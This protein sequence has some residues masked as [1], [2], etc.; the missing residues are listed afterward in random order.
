[1]TVQRHVSWP[2]RVVFVLVLVGTFLIGGKW[3]YEL[4]R[5]FAGFGEDLHAE[6]TR[7]RGE[8][9]SLRSERESL[10]KSEIAAQSRLS[11]ERSTQ[12]QLGK[13]IKSLEIENAKLKDDISFFENL[14]ASGPL[15]GLAIKRM[16]VERDV[17]PGQFHYRILVTQGGKIDHDFNGDL[18]LLVSLQH[19]GKTV[20]MNLPGDA[21]NAGA[22]SFLVNFRFFERL[23]G[24]F[25]IPTGAVVKQVE[26]RILEKGTVRAQQTVMVS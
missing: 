12:D 3:V 19:E 22:K 15:T 10:T 18:Q 13:Q 9:E 5:D 20:I 6:V 17:L 2:V 24:T 26:A 25:Q 7:L 4:G 1:M 16:V 23:E 8:N 14:S 11:I 21:P